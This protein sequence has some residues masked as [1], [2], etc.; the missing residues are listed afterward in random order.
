MS[1][2]KVEPGVTT[3]P[4]PQNLTELRAQ[5][6]D[7]TAVLPQMFFNVR[8]VAVIMGEIMPD[9]RPKYWT[10]TR[11]IDSGQLRTR[12]SGKHYIV[13]GSAILEFADGADEP[14]RHGEPPIRQAS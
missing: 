1:P 8:Q 11:L 3:A 10:I 7:A 4:V 14:M 5:M 13:P 6:D 9:G 2:R 12:R